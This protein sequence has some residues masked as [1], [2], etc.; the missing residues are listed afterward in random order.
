M[1][2]V[3]YDG[4]NCGYN[5]FFYDN[6]LDKVVNFEDDNDY[7]VVDIFN[8]EGITFA[9]LEDETGNTHFLSD[10]FFVCESLSD[11]FDEDKELDRLYPS[12]VRNPYDGYEDY[13]YEMQRDKELLGW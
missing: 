5:S 8:H 7:I 3:N 10:D 9:E 1:S 6:I 13:L 12:F 2:Y 4:F 11:Y